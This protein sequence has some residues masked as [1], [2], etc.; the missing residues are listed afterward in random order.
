MAGTAE[1][2]EQRAA[3]RHEQRGAIE[4]IF[5]TEIKRAGLSGE[6][7][8][9]RKWASHAVPHFARCADLVIV[10]Q[11]DPTDPESYAGDHFPETVILSSGRPVL[12]LPYTGFFAQVGK[13][14]M[15]A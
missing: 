9:T 6:W 3:I 1:Y 15:I 10:S 8:E 14:P 4:R 11:D 13:H 7:I 2:Y 12:L 5:H